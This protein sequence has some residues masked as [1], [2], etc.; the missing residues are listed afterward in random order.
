M[1]VHGLGE[2]S[3]RYAKLA[4]NLNN[5]HFAVYAPDL[6][7]H[8]RSGGPRAFINR[9]DYAV[10]DVDAVVTFAAHQHPGLPITLLGHSMGGLVATHYALAHD[11]RLER[12]VL[13]APLAKIKASPPS[14]LMARTLGALLPKLGVYRINPKN[15]SRDEA[16]V[17]AYKSDP[18]VRHKGIPSRTLV[19]LIKSVKGMHRRAGDIKLPTLIMYGT[20]DKLCPPE[21]SVKLGEKLGSSDKE[22]KSYQ[23]LYHEILNEP[24][25][26]QV[27]TDMCTWIETHVRGRQAVGAGS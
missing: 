13:S 11:D 16:V 25:R 19:V 12:L 24:E 15:I 7:G 20:A 6:R 2:H 3:G 26:D 1:V 22:V 14:R 21:G 23:D 18:L 10:A 4:E 8:G 17:E 5:E 9:M 27:I